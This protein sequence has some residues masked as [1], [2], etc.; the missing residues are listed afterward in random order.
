MVKQTKTGEKNQ[1]ATKYTYQ[2]AVKHSH[3]HYLFQDPPNIPKLGF[4]VCK[5]S[6]WQPCITIVLTIPRKTVRNHNMYNKNLYN[7]KW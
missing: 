2:M 6:L 5:Y 3:K 4:L 7:K 1:M